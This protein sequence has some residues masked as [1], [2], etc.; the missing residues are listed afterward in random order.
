MGSGFGCGFALPFFQGLCQLFVG[1][2]GVEGRYFGVEVFLFDAAQVFV[3]GLEVLVGILVVVEGL[4]AVELFGFLFVAEGFFEAFFVDA[5]R[6]FLLLV[7]VEQVLEVAVTQMAFA[8]RGVFLFFVE[9]LAEGGE[10]LFLAVVGVVVEEGFVEVFGEGVYLDF[11]LDHVDGVDGFEGDNKN[12]L[13]V[14]LDELLQIVVIALRIGFFEL[15][16]QVVREVLIADNQVI[17]V[18][19]SSLHSGRI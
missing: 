10:F 18:F 17:F 19:F 16:F 2:G 11:K 13:S 9:G 4:V 7:F 14:G 8:V 1:D 12:S 3:G 15:F 5:E 6:G